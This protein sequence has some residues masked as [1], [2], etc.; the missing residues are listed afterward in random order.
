MIQ[1]SYGGKIIHD[2]DI[3]I[4]LRN[5]PI[6]KFNTTYIV[7]SADKEGLASFL[8]SMTLKRKKEVKNR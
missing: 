3:E 5:H 4:T 7:E 6:K 1:L 2:I 8:G